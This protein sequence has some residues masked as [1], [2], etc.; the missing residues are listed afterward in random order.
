MP[1]ARDLVARR[2][3]F[4]DLAAEGVLL[5]LLKDGFLRD[6]F[7]FLRFAGFFA[8]AG[9]ERALAFAAGFGLD[10]VARGRVESVPVLL[11]AI[12]PTSPPTTAP[13]GPTK[14]PRTAPVAAPAASF[15]IEGISIF[16]EGCELSSG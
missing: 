10:A 7:G 11:P 13:T 14:L 8:L 3:D 2:T 16:S 5:R 4:L 1:F 6:G 9:F 15:E 12:A